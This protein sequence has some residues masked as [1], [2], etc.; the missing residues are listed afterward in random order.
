MAPKARMSWYDPALDPPL[1]KASIANGG[2]LIE[3]AKLAAETNRFGQASALTVLSVEEMGKAI[4]LRL[5]M[6]LG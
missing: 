6:D 3:T 4:G 1:L 2:A 5:A